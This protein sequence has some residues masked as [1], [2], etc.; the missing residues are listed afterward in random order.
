MA[1]FASSRPHYVHSSSN[2][3]IV[4]SNHKSL[5]NT[6]KEAANHHPQRNLQT[7]GPVTLQQLEVIQYI[8]RLLNQATLPAGVDLTQVNV[9]IIITEVLQELGIDVSTTEIGDLSTVDVDLIL[10]EISEKAAETL[11]VMI[12]AIANITNVTLP[13]TVPPPTTVPSESCSI[14]GDGKKVGNPLAVLNMPGQPEVLC[15][16]LETAGANGVIP[17]HQCAF[18]SNII[19]DVCECISDEDEVV[20]TTTATVAPPVI[21]TGPSCVCSPLS[22][23]FTLNLNRNCETDTFI[24]NPGISDTVCQDLPGIGLAAESADTLIVYDVQFLEVDTSGNL[25]VINQDDTYNNVSL[26]TG[27][28]ITFDSVSANL[29]PD[30]PLSSQLEY[31]PGGVLMKLV[32]RNEGSDTIVRQQVSWLYT[33]SCD[34]L[35]TS[36]GDAIGWI[37]LVSYEEQL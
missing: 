33:N 25:I 24:D 29:N 11:G 16:A 3:D 1:G 6:N 13:T 26:T 12:E 27:D 34:D 32:A 36:V 31:V 37:A 23:T 30:E 8:I 15:G 2:V 21:T 5:S 4:S 14:C 10:Q 18:L 35:P 28:T 19:S 20:T 17:S 9:A 7:E 22:Y